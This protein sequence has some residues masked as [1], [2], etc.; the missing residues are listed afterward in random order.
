MSVQKLCES[1]GIVL[2][3]DRKAPLVVDG[4]AYTLCI[5]ES[6]YRNAVE[7]VAYHAASDWVT[8]VTLES[9]SL[10]RD[11]LVARIRHQHDAAL[12]WADAIRAGREREAPTAP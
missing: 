2:D 1:L 5:R 10:T 6:P 3:V 11:E 9:E 7:V 4:V 12:A 8:S